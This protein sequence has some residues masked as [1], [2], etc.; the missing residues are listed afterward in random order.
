MSAFSSFAHGDA[1]IVLQRDQGDGA[2]SRSFPMPGAG[3]YVL[4]PE[5]TNADVHSAVGTHLVRSAMGGINTTLLA[6]GQTGAGKTHSLFGGLSS[7][8]GPATGE[9][10]GEEQGLVERVCGTLFDNAEALSGRNPLLSFSFTVLTL[11]VQRGELFDCASADTLK[12]GRVKLRTHKVGGVYLDP[13]ATATLVTSSAKLMDEVHKAQR[14]MLIMHTNMSQR[15]SNTTFVVR[16]L[17]SQILHPGPEDSSSPPQTLSSSE[18]NFVDLAGSERPVQAFGQGQGQREAAAIGA[19][20]TA[21]PL[22]RCVAALADGDKHVP[23]RDSPLTYLLKP[24][25]GGNCTTVLL[26][27]LRP[28]IEHCDEQGRTLMAAQ[29]AQRCRNKLS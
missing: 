23:H 17:F 10:Q 1:G 15:T 16:V 3:T 14:A 11:M 19:G 13:P 24:A 7:V 26:A 9:Q 28:T 5:A 21:E 22:M 29:R 4:G 12:A 25:F 2:G 18:I 27:C 6:Y 8:S 20:A